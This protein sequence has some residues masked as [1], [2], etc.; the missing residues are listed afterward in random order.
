MARLQAAVTVVD[1]NVFRHIWVNATWY[2]AVCLKLYGG[3]FKH[4]L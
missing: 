2:T 4:V 3:C 1:A